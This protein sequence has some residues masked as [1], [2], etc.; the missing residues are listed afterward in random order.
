M[1]AIISE[2]WDKV[3]ASQFNEPYIFGIQTVL[4]RD[5]SI[6]CPKIQDVWNAFK[7]TPFEDVR[8]VILGQD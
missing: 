2:S 7:L 5:V 3:M 8:V 6:L 4:K 1:S